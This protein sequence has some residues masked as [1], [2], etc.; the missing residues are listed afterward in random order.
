[1]TQAA[2]QADLPGALPARG[3]DEAERLVRFGGPP[4][5]FLAEL[6][7]AQCR[8][9]GA[10]GG[11]VLRRA[12]GGPGVECLQSVPPGAAGRDPEEEAAPP[13]LREVAGVVG[14][15]GGW[16]REAASFPLESGD[17]LYGEDGQRH[18]VV[19]PLGAFASLDAVAAFVLEGCDADEAHHACRR[20]AFTLS[21]LTLYEARQ[22]LGAREADLRGLALATGTLAALNRQGRFGSAG[23]AFCNEVASRFEAE[24]VSFGVVRGRYVKLR[25]MSQTEHVHRKMAAVQ[26]I[27]AAME[28]CLDQDTEVQHPAAP[29]EPVVAR[30][31]AE[32]AR[33][34]SCDAV[35]SLPLR[36]AGEAEAVV[37]LER[38]SR[39]LD[40]AEASFLRLACELCGPR[41]LEMEAA[42]RWVGARAAASVRRGLALFVG[43]THTWAKAAAIG[44]LAAL[45]VVTLVDVPFRVDAPFEL[46]AVTRRQ[47]P[48][49]FEG[50]L[51]TVAV[52]AGDV[53][54]AG[55]VLGELDTS[56]LQ[57]ERA[58]Q[59]A[60]RLTHQKEADEARREGKTVDVQIAE[61]RAAEAQVQVELNDHQIAQATLR[62][63][64]AGSVISDDLQ[65]KLFSPVKRGELLFEVARLGQQRAEMRVSDED[66][67]WV[68]EGQTGSLAPAS[69]P[70]DP[71]GFRVGRIEPIAEV[72]DG[73]N[74]FRVRLEL[75]ESRPWFRPGVAGVAKI[76]VGKGSILWVY[77]REAVNFVRLKL[78]L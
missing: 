17:G 15:A 3:F 42:D 24:R 61:A 13:W 66:I 75:L 28:E 20:L 40:A 70:G 47:V 30:A 63:P 7:L 78:W 14:G 35:I 77:T 8:F 33:R 12:E 46:Q 56:E 58:R 1:M 5:A 27:E 48:A 22:A 25:A 32:L 73:E 69:T 21:M 52:R 23:L 9:A 72:V 11:A 34:E 50:Y 16:P 51:A 39:G 49:P 41:L 67:P 60:E 43:P 31:A 38:A 71:V 19:L 2:I 55:D 45:A 68:R 36:R 76:D 65:Q 74:V 29:E 44:L 62:A 10:A 57:L 6:L 37:T 18:A 53:V 59:Q 26:A 64:V 54:Q 4:D